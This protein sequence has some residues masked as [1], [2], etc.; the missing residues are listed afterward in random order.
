MSYE[1]LLVNTDDQGIV[2]VTL[3][4]PEK[5]NAMS[6]EM[7]AELT[8]VGRTLGAETTSRAMVLSGA[9]KMICAIIQFRSPPAQN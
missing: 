3:N 8:D 1:T 5:R 4:R 9:G 2:H 7:I 6:A